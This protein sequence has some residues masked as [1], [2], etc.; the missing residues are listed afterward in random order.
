VH[1]GLIAKGNARGLISFLVLNAENTIWN[2]LTFEI[3]Y[4]KKG[5]FPIKI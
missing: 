1:S 4:Y 3:I 5:V 2:F